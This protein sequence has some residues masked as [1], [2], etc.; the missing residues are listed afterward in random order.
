MSIK[1]LFS[2]VFWRMGHIAPAIGLVLLILAVLSAVALSN[3]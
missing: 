3:R 1:K 2:V